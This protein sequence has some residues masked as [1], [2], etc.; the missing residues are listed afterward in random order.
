MTPDTIAA[1]ADL[2]DG[3]FRPRKT[4]PVDERQ[5]ELF[6]SLPGIPW[7]PSPALV[8]ELWRRLARARRPSKAAEEA[9]QEARSFQVIELAAWRR[10][11]GG[12]L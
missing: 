8:S 6:Q 7:H 9:P 1:L 12:R 5:L 10:E 3:R 11:R 4:R 2:A